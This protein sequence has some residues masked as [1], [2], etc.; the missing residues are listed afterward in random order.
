[1]TDEQILKFVMKENAEGTSQAQIVTKL[2]Q[3]G[4]TIE[5]IRRVKDKYERQAKNKGLGTVSSKDTEE[6]NGRQ[7]KNNGKKGSSKNDDDEESPQYR[8]KDTRE[9]KKSKSKEVVYD[10][11]NEDWL[12]MQDELNTFIPDTT[13]M[14]EKLLAEKRKKKVFGRDIFNNKDLTFE[15][16]MN[17]ATPQNYI[18]GPGDAVYIDIYG[19]SQKTIES[20]VSPDG[21]V[22]IEGFGPVQVSGLTVAQANARLRST[23]GAR[24]SS[25]KIKLTVGQTR[26]IMI[27]VMGEVKNPGTYTLPAFATV[28]H[29]LYM[30]GGTND[31]GTMRNIKVYRNNRLVS[32]V[33]IY[34]Y[35]LNGKLTGNVRLAD[36]DVISVGPY[37]CL[38]NITGKVKRP[39]YYEMKR[40]ES[41]GTLLKYAGGFTGDAYKKSVRIVRK[42]G[43]EYSVYNVDEFDMSAFH[44]ADEDSVSVDSI[45]PRFSNMVEVKGAVFRPGMYQVG[46][47]INSV[48]TL[49]EHADGLR[50][51]AF[52]ARAVMHRMKK[53]RTLEVVPVDVEGILDGTVPDIPIQNNDVLFIP[54]KQEM[55]EEQTITIHGEVQYPG[56]Y[57]YADNETLEDFVLQAGGLKQTAS[58]VKV[59]VSRRIVNPKALTTDSVIARTYTFALKDGF[60]IDGTPGFKLMPFDEVYVRKSPGY[61]KQQNVVVEGEVMFSGTYTLSKKNQRLSDLI[62]SAGGVNDRGYIAGARLERKVNESERARMEAVLKKAK[63]EA[64]QMEIEAAKENKKIDLKD[65]EKIKKFEIPEF[66]SVGIELDKAL[67]NPGCDADIVLREGDKIIVPQYNG[68]VKING[69]VMYPNTVGFQKGKKAKYY[70][71]QAGGFSE[72][73]KKSQTY[74]VYMNGTIAKVSQNAKPKPGCEIVVPEKEINKMTIAE[75]MTIGTSV[76][77]IATMI[78]TLANIL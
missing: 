4:V 19:A 3:K 15:P 12:M 62:K 61:Y 78:A 42:T 52:T 48:K 23:L 11:T 22:T 54:T 71:N 9:K 60:V 24:Y 7:R 75:K 16:N 5:Q 2:M 40:N 70:I 47:D 66:Y 37:D 27:N 18:L 30:A 72:K 50:E 17:I 46:G 73:A 31:I 10:E 57:R 20:T 26:S 53:D 29:A 36:N 25:S 77:S 68:T 35:I 64:E 63:E 65:S 38:V 14:L 32:V 51:E 1:M 34:D 49:I 21:E 56:I 74:I 45:L 41:V 39:M 76:A 33:D 59:D 67:A 69:A 8:I 43:R 55:M 28:F 58:T 44:L 13:A 6:D